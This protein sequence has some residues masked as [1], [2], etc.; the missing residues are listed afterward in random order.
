MSGEQES[1]T[2]RPPTGKYAEVD[3]ELV[4]VGALHEWAG[5]IARRERCARDESLIA[6]AL[7][8]VERD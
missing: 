8:E 5:K 1:V 7:R 6:E 4:E 2:K 3:G